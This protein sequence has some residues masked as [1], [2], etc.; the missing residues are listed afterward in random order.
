[1]TNIYRTD[2]AP[3]IDLRRSADYWRPLQILR[4]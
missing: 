1:L 3:A 2:L 4:P